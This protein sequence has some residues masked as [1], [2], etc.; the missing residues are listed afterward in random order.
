MSMTVEFTLNAET[1]REAIRAIAGRRAAHE[2]RYAIPLSD[3][4]ADQLGDELRDMDARMTDA[5]RLL[6][7]RDHLSSADLSAM[8]HVLQHFSEADEDGG[9]T[10]DDREIAHLALARLLAELTAREP[11]LS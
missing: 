8:A 9:V 7:A 6:L 10:L 11:Q 3:E 2:A 5:A 1:A 4:E